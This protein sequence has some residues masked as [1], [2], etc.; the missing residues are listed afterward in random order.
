MDLSLSR[1]VEQATLKRRPPDNRTQR[2]RRDESDPKENGKP[3]QVNAS[4]MPEMKD[5]SAVPGLAARTFDEEP[6]QTAQWKVNDCN[7]GRNIL[8]PRVPVFPSAKHLRKIGVAPRRHPLYLQA[9][10][11]ARIRLLE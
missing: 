5:S 6:A 11:V 9:R 1:K 10:L 3:N 4:L 7:I 8:G 2:Q